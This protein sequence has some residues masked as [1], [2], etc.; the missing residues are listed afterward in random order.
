MENTSNMVMYIFVNTD[1]KRDRPEER[2][3][4][5]SAQ[6]AHV[7][8]NIIDI[9]VRDI[10]ETIPVPEYCDRYLRWC[11]DPTMVILRANETQLNQLLKLSETYGFRDDIPINN[12]SKETKSMLTC[13]GLYPNNIHNF[14]EYKLL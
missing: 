13:V 8:H 7:V 4:L 3:G 1:I 5:C 11:D 10:Y 12:K 9:I 14:S 2:K 6:V